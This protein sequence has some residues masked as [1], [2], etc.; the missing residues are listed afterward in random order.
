MAEEWRNVPGYEE[1]QICL[2]DVR[3]RCRRVYM[4]GKIKELSNKPDKNNRLTWSL[5]SNG[6]GKS[7]QAA[8]WIAITFPEIVQN[9]YFDGAYIDHIDTNPM[10]NQP[11]NLRWV[12][13]KENCN[14]PR[15]LERKKGLLKG[16]VFSPETIE[17]MRHA[18]TG[19]VLSEE[20]KKKMSESRK[21]HIV[22]P[23]TR[24]KIA[25]GRSIPIC[26][27]TTDYVLV[28]TYNST[29]EAGKILCLDARGIS[30]CVNDRRKTFKGYIWRR[31]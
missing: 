10:N 24:R 30:K 15:T 17:K 18:Q 6:L 20:T 1:Y 26:Q 11:S 22:T 4:N 3:G 27:Y 8:R 29:K 16:R 14:N 21:G 9:E 5:Y 12:T 31:K 2:D 13:P 7:A 28:A 23:E 19:R 25:A